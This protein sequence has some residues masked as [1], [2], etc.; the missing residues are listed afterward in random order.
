MEKRRRVPSLC[1]PPP[2][3]L[4]TIFNEENKNL[5]NSVIALNATIYCWAYHLINSAEMLVH[6]VT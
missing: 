1:S 4:I 5:Q 3:N 6:F 2:P